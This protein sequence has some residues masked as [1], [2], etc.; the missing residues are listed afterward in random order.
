MPRR[1]CQVIN[2]LQAVLVDLEHVEAEANAAG[3]PVIIS[4][5]RTMKLTDHELQI[6]KYTAEGKT[7]GEIAAILSC[8]S[9]TVEGNW[10]RIFE[11]IGALNRPH[12]IAI[13]FQNKT[14]Y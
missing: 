10:Q 14:L 9:R 12:A 5:S 11:K 2:D 4:R 3:K 13:L 6:V 1:L 8:S 7:G